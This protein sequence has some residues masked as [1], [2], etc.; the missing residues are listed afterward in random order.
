MVPRFFLLI[1]SSVISPPCIIFLLK[2]GLCILR[3]MYPRLSVLYH[4][5][6]SVFLF[7]VSPVVRNILQF[8]SLIRGVITSVAS[9]AS[10]VTKGEFRSSEQIINLLNSYGT[11]GNVCDLQNSTDEPHVVFHLS[12]LCL[13]FTDLHF[14]PHSLIW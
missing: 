14:K 7:P 9:V 8:L 10:L 13:N 1:F 12:V 5:Y 11:H 3:R 2:P 6:F 4:P